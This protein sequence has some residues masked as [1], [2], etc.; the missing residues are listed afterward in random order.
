MGRTLDA[1]WALKRARKQLKLDAELTGYFLYSAL[2]SE[3]PSHV[4]KDAVEATLALDSLSTH[5]LLEASRLWLS[6]KKD[7]SRSEEILAELEALCAE[8]KCPVEVTLIFG[9]ILLSLSMSARSLLH[10]RKALCSFPK[11]PR[12]LSL[13]ALSYLNS[14]DS[15]NHEFATQ[16]ALSAC[17]ATK[18]SSARELHVLAEAYYHS[19]DKMT[20]LIVASKAKDEGRRLLGSYRDQNGLEELIQTLSTQSIA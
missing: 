1:A 17:Q 12:L 11:H 8:E 6:Q 2:E 3:A 16:L 4:L 15:Y 5:P 10:L 18:W 7:P 20:A 9:E 14:G 13:I 19:G